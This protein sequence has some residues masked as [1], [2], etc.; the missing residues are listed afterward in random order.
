MND[1]SFV[2]HSF[3]QVL[4]FLEMSRRERR[5]RDCYGMRTFL[6]LLKFNSCKKINTGIYSASVADILKY[7]S[8]CKF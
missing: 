5:R 2:Q 6:D 8:F 1:T 3:L 7:L 4:R